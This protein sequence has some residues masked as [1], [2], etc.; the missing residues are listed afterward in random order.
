MRFPLRWRGEDGVGSAEEK[1]QKIAEEKTRGERSG[2]SN[3]ILAAL[4]P[5]KNPGLD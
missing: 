4:S 2:D 3:N 1:L 5:K